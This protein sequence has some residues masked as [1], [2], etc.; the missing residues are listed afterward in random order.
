MAAPNTSD[1]YYDLGRY[2]RAITTQSPDAETWFNRGLIWC[3]GFNHE[4]AVKCFERAITA[5]AGCAMAYWGVAY[6][7]GPNYNKPWGF[8]DDEEL[9]TVVQ[10]THRMVEQARKCAESGDGATPLE[11]ALVEALRYRYPREHAPGDQAEECP[12]WNVQYADAMQRVHAE[13]GSDLDV[14]ALCAD[15]LMNLT[16]WK[17]WD[18]KTGQPAQGARTRQVQTILDRALQQTPGGMQHPGV[19]HLYI[20]Y[21][22]MSP[23]PEAG[24]AAADALRTLVP[25]A[26]H[27]N[28]MP[29]H[30][31]VLCGDY[32]RG[33]ASNRAAFA[34]DEKFLARAG[35]L[36]FYTLYRMHDYHFCI[37][38]ALFAGQSRVALDTVAR[39]EASLSA[40]ADL[41]EVR[42][43]PMA[44]WLEGF[45]A[46]RVHALVRFGRW[47]DLVAL[48]LPQ[49]QALYCVTTAMT[50]YA[51]AVALAATSRLPE[52]EAE[53]RRFLEA[54]TRVPESRTLFNN[55]CIDLLAIAEAMMEGEVAFRRGRF[56]EAYAHLRQAVARDDGLPYDEPWGWMQPTRHAYG[57]LLMEREHYAEAAAVY[58]EDLGLDDKLPRQLRHPGNVWALHG[59]HECLVRLGREEEAAA[60]E[61]KLREALEGADVP[62]KSSCFCRRVEAQCAL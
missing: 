6:A 24:L 4:E 33:I 53:R 1:D 57:A 48:A 10:R 31:D 62:I 51:K 2:R 5:D 21:I 7:L 25:D 44:D 56:D 42:S 32:R 37:Y 46:M 23:T 12:I 13:F 58:A 3:Y 50:H 27:L 49:D 60:V 22:E 38:A 55:R 30:I 26:G 28:H 20:H 47:A 14:A 16:P 19:L 11:K 9:E 18:L 35:A 43:P 39:M 8:F 17:L 52:A 36:N 40:S 45:F 41:L 15:A 29:T 59:Y 54:R 61:P 34:S